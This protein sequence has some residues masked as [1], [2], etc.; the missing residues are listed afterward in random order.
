MHGFAGG[1]NSSG[2]L[3]QSGI[4]SNAVV[5]GNGY[6]VYLNQEDSNEYPSH[7]IPFIPNETTNTNSGKA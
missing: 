7:T 5:D 6:I 4:G 3:S 2:Y 1:T